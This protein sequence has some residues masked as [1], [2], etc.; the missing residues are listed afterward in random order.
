MEDGR[1]IDRNIASEKV[2]TIF[3]MFIADDSPLTVNISWRIKDKIIEQVNRVRDSEYPDND[4]DF[5]TLYQDA[6]MVI[7]KLMVSDPFMR[8]K[9][10]EEYRS[11]LL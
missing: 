10:T 2:I 3:D 5:P 7:L 11:L 1:S 6:E 9:M 4:I 8:F